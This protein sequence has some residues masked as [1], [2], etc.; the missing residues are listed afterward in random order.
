MPFAVGSETIVD[1]HRLRLVL[2]W[3]I[4][5]RWSGPGK[6]REILT[7]LYDGDATKMEL[8][9]FL[10]RSARSRYAYWKND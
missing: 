3:R 6:P 8:G 4:T 7:R 1:H 10:G 9:V 5:T 2:R